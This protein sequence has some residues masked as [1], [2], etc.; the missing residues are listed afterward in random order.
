MKDT[1]TRT[2][3]Y[4]TARLNHLYPWIDL[5]ESGKL[6]SVYSN[7]PFDLEELLRS[8]I[9]IA[10]RREQLRRE[11]FSRESTISEEA[12]EEFF[13][14]LEANEP[15]NCEHVVPQSWL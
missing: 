12:M 5:Q 9:A 2:L 6:H 10:E 14:G 3:S 1:H 15:F 4:K 8:E 7:K 11:F 13:D